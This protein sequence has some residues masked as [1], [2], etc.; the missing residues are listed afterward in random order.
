MII[1]KYTKPELDYFREQCNF[2]GVEIDVF[3]MRSQK[4]PLEIIA[5]KLD[6]TIDG[7]KKISKDVNNKITRV[8]SLSRHF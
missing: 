1:S 8:N 4:I 2:V 7:I 5:E 3:E 6:Y